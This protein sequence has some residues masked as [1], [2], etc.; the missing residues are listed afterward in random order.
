MQVATKAF[1]LGKGGRVM[2]AP[3]ISGNGHGY[4]DGYGGK[5]NSK[6]SIRTCV[7]RGTRQEAGIVVKPEAMQKVA[8]VSTFADFKPCFELHV[9]V[10]RDWEGTPSASKETGTPRWFMRGYL[11]LHLRTGD[12]EW[13]P[14][15]LAG[16]TF[17]TE[18]FFDGSGMLAKPPVF[19]PKTFT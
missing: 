4:W 15:V 7:M 18:L 12:R 16:E 9:F 13:L 1:L 19:A 3:R 14:R 11:P 6:E 2:L 10:F 8:V 5:C 17:V